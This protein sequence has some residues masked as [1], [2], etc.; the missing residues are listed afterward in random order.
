MSRR[1]F[2]KAWISSLVNDDDD[3]LRVLLLLLLLDGND[4]GIGFDIVIF[5][6]LG[7]R[8]KFDGIVIEITAQKTASGR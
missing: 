2:D 7:G 3:T 6:N 1:T 4:G 8:G 5:N